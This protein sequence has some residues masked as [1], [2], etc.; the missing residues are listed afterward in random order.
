[1][2]L[3]ISCATTF[4][5]LAADQNRSLPNKVGFRRRLRRAHSPPRRD[6]TEVSGRGASFRSKKIMLNQRSPPCPSS[7]RE[8]A[9]PGP[10]WKTPCRTKRDHHLGRRI[11]DGRM[12]K[13]NG[14][15][16]RLGAPPARCSQNPWEGPPKTFPE[17]R[18]AQMTKTRKEAARLVHA[19]NRRRRSDPVAKD[20]RCSKGVWTEKIRRAASDDWLGGSALRGDLSARIRD[21]AAT[22][23][24]PEVGWLPWLEGGRVRAADSFR[25]VRNDGV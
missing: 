9:D 19:Y 23:A 20:A 16:L 7:S 21:K 2:L 13:K 8:G 25:H 14:G 10:S 6:G 24:A 12:G 5:N 22:H 3:S 15:C 17:Y 1:V 11:T 4:L 18:V